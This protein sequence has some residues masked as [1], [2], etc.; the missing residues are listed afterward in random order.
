MKPK[1]FV[2]T[3]DNVILEALRRDGPD[4]EMR[5]VESLG[6]PGSADVTLNLPHQSATLTDLTGARPQILD[7]A[8]TYQFS[9]RPQ[10]IVTLRFRT[11]TPVP[12]ITPLTQWD[13]LVPA[14]ELPALH[15]YLKDVKGHP[16]SGS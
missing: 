1:S 11:G 2:Q 3:S 13:E 4:I 12:Q 7:G 9:V 8:P 10:Q 6:Q 5:L 14:R 15:D 16:P